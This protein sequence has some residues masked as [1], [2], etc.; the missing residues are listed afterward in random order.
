MSAQET[1][2]PAWLHAEL[3]TALG[4][5]PRGVRSLGGGDV[6]EAWA[7]EL[8]GRT[9]F[10]KAR[11]TAR[12]Q[13]FVAEAAGLMWL[14]ET[15][16]VAVPQ[17]LAVGDGEEGD[18][19]FLALEWV[20]P[21][22]GGDLSTDA[23]ER[24]GRGLAA[25]HR[26]GAPVFGALPPRAPAGPW[27]M[28][29]LLLPGPAPPDGTPPD[30]GQ[31]YVDRRLK[32]LLGIARSRNALTKHG[33]RAVEKVC[34][35][36]D[37]LA[38]PR[39]PPARLHGDLWRGNVLAGADGRAWL[40]D[41]AAYGGHRE[42]DLAMLELF[43]S[44]GPNVIPAYR[45]AWPLADGYEERIPL[46]QLLPLLVHAVLFGGSYGAQVEDAAYSLL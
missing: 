32:P 39:E 6:N 10:V 43:G 29:T 26:A 11:A 35:R 16:E 38:G 2:L 25:M 23:Q 19:G 18:G 21:R 44:P 45:E 46:W 7:V 24:L 8:P 28:A 12:P 3:T 4:A 9:V 27:R 20:P 40:I 33:G 17:V 5:I 37:E 15:G 36:I 34:E 30:W 22:A 13:E 42:V 1:L 31:Y 14:G 41:P